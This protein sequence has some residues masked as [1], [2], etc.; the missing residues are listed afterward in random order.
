MPVRG[1]PVS[2]SAPEFSAEEEEEERAKLSLEERKIIDDELHGKQVFDFDAF[3][4]PDHVSSFL[5]EFD[6]CIRN[7]L[8]PELTETYFEAMEKVP[9]LVQQETDPLMFLRAEFFD[10]EN[11]ARRL[12]MHWKER[13]A[14]FGDDRA[15]LPMT[16]DRNGALGSSDADVHQLELGYG[17]RTPDDQHGRAVVFLDRANSTRDQRYDRDSWLRVMWYLIHTISWR[18]ECQKSGYVF[19][20]NLKDYDPHSCG[21]RLGAKK[22]FEFMRE[23]W[24]PRLK[25]FHALYGSRQSATR[26]IE[27]AVRKMQGRHIRLHIRNH[28]GSNIDLLL[29]LSKYGLTTRQSCPVVGGSFTVADQISWMKRKEL[30]EHDEHEHLI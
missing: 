7:K 15:F 10:V 19:V 13:K 6:R 29:S 2:Y 5:D 26:L 20:V 24:C 4:T 16:L 22:L 30:G 3:E 23:C 27:P 9:H 21:D 11:A 28:Y 17:V 18:P 1:W 14:L 25:A 12:A 8:P